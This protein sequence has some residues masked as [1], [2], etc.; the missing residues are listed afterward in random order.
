MK[1]FFYSIGEKIVSLPETFFLANKN[2]R[3]L[4]L[5]YLNQIL[6]I[7]TVFRLI[8][9]QTEFRLFPNQSENGEYNL[10]SV[11][12]PRLSSRFLLK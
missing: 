7:I 11:D 4:N 9:H 2:I 3:F 12:L 10:I 5:G 6:I 8:E 1:I